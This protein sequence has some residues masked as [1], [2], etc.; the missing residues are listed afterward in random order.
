MWNWL[1]SVTCSKILVDPLFDVLVGGSREK[2]GG[3]VEES[4]CGTDSEQ[5]EDV[6]VENVTLG[7][8]C[9]CGTVPPRKVL[10]DVEVDLEQE[11]NLEEVEVDLEQGV[12]LEQEVELV[13]HFEL[14]EHVKASELQR[15]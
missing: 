12:V 3:E 4:V 2:E 5:V 11:V 7:W 13:G 9:R 6:Y 10:V 15:W 14:E 8:W 1:H